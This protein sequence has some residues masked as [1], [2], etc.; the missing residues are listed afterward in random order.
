M[1]SDNSDMLS[2][3]GGVSWEDSATLLALAKAHER[4]GSWS[5]CKK[6][7]V[8]TIARL[9]SSLANS[10]VT[11]FSL[12]KYA[13]TRDLRNYFLTCGALGSTTTFCR[14]NMTTLY[15]PS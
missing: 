6:T 1:T 12:T 5:S 9:E 7:P 13:G 4:L 14:S 2:F 10:S 3:G 11:S 8:G 15:W